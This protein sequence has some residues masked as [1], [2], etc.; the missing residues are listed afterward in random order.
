MPV[1]CIGIVALMEF[2]VVMWCL[3]QAALST[4]R[5]AELSETVFSTDRVLCTVH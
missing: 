3:Q 1:K 5:T 2:E 4:Q